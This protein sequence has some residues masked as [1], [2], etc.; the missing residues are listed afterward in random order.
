MRCENR[1]C[2]YY[3]GDAC[4]LDDITLDMLGQC[5]SCI[6]VNL[7]ESLLDRVRAQMRATFDAMDAIPP[8]APK[9]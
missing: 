5:E 4:L 6:Y 8:Y 3:E 7:P 9:A 2:I 1:F